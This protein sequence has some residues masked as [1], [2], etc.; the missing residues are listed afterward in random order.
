MICP[1]HPVCAHTVPGRGWQPRHQVCRHFC[2]RGGASPGTQLGR[3]TGGAEPARGTPT[4]RGRGR[5]PFFGVNPTSQPPLPVGTRSPRPLRVLAPAVTSF[6]H[7]ALR[8][9]SHPSAPAFPSLPRPVQAE[10]GPR[11]PSGFG[12]CPALGLPSWALAGDGHRRCSSGSHGV[13]WQRKRAEGGQQ[14][15]AAAATPGH[16]GNK[17]DSPQ[18]DPLLGS[19]LAVEPGTAASLRQALAAPSTADP[20]DETDSPEPDLLLSSAPPEPSTNTSPPR[21]LMVPTTAD[22]L[23]ETDSPEPDSLPSSAPEPSTS[24]PQAHTAPTT[25]D[26]LDETDSPEPD[27]LL[28]SAPP[29]PSTNTS[30]PRA[31]AAPTTADPLDE[32]DSPEPD[33]LLSSESP[34]VPGTQAAPQKSITTLPSWLTS[35]GEEETVAYDTDSSS[36]AEPRSVTPPA[37][38]PTTTSYKKVKKAGATPAPT[39][40]TRQ[41]TNPGGTVAPVPWDPSRVMSKC[42]LAILLLALV[43]ATF[44]VCTG[45]LGAR[46]WR[47]ARTAH[48]RLSPTEMVCISSLLPDGEVAANGPKPGPARRQKLLLDGGSEADGDN[49]TLSS[50][51][52]EHA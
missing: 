19:A 47:R 29:E 14:P 25:A 5:R 48:R 37:L 17:T 46:L 52:P 30:P 33:L 12:S 11:H 3:A 8:N 23:D 22:P 13:P 26:P 1:P 15:S 28:S 41:G 20:L 43:A 7:Q 34:A 16:G 21:A 4:T 32:T 38:S 51:L 6:P 10:G 45:V 2:F 31:L 9:H 36:S 42:L 39:H 24:P 49:L 40:P 18:H 27:L 44:M 35:L 50:F